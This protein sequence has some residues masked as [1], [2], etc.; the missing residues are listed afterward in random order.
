VVDQIGRV[1]QDRELGAVL[2]EVAH[3]RQPSPSES[4]EHAVAAGDL[5]LHHR[6]PVDRI[7]IAQA[8]LEQMTVVTSDPLFDR[9]EVPVLP[10]S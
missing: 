2:D 9:Y 8:R 7:L 1:L 6:D 5:P 3:V 4:I 10:A